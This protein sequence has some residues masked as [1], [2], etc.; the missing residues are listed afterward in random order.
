MGL[1]TAMSA[2][3]GLAQDGLRGQGCVRCRP[4]LGHFSRLP[5]EAVMMVPLTYVWV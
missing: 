5:S 1:P 3:A 2:E 4:T